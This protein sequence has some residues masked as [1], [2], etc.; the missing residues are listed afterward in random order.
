M[1]NGESGWGY[2]RGERG[3]VISFTR[4]L[5]FMPLQMAPTQSL[6]KIHIWRCKNNVCF[7]FLSKK[8]ANSDQ[9]HTIINQHF[10][11]PAIWCSTLEIKTV[12]NIAALI[13]QKRSNLLFLTNPPFILLQ[14]TFKGPILII[15]IILIVHFFCFSSQTQLCQISFKLPMKKTKHV[16]PCVYSLQQKQ[17]ELLKRCFLWPSSVSFAA[18]FL[19]WRVTFDTR[20]LLVMFF[21]PRVPRKQ[22][23]LPQA[24]GRVISN[25]F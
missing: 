23:T 4:F 13:E 19:A 6:S 12:L 9:S 14:A 16:E 25:S 5:A 2:G 7:F 24:M 17:T 18:F 11:V 8:R 22:R 3:V 20:L 15:R 21:S 10:S 1:K